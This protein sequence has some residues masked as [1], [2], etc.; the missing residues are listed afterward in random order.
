MVTLALMLLPAPNADLR[1]ARRC[2]ALDRGAF[3]VIARRTSSLTP[4]WT[5]PPPACSGLPASPWASP[6]WRPRRPV[7]GH[8]APQAASA[9]RARR[10]GIDD[11]R[12]HRPAVRQQVSSSRSARAAPRAA[13]R[14]CGLASPRRCYRWW[15]PGRLLR[16]PA[17]CDA[18]RTFRLSDWAGRRRSARAPRRCRATASA[19]TADSD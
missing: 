16:S 18:A 5:P 1:I 10:P 3:V 9:R 2:R 11:D 6:A 17:A 15:R 14:T 12:D 8:R 19:T 7:C 4:A 13:P